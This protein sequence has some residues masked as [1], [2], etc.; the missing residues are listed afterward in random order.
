MYFGWDGI[1]VSTMGMDRGCAAQGRE[2]KSSGGIPGLAGMI[3][4]AT[5][6]L[7][8]GRLARIAATHICIECWVSL[9]LW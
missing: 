3:D 6:E 2:P 9:G 5:G 7:E 8:A 1:E 4:V